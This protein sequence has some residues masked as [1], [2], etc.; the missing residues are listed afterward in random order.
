[1][2]ALVLP[3]AHLAATADGID[4]TA[5]PDL[6]ALSAKA[7]SH[8]NP[9]NHATLQPL[10]DDLN[11]QVQSAANA[12]SGVAATLLGYT[13]PQWNANHDL[14]TPSRGSVLA[15]NDDIKKAQNDATQIRSILRSTTLSP[16]A[17]PTTA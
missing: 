1:V 2:L 7:A 15:A 5:I 10:I 3:A 14:L 17:A 9:S 16:S 4:A 12:T 8:V 11:A 13:P 6:T